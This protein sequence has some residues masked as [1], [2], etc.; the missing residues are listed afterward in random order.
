MPVNWISEL[1]IGD[2][3]VTVETGGKWILKNKSTVIN[4]ER[5]YIETSFFRELNP[6]IEDGL[7]GN[8]RTYDKQFMRNYFAPDGSIGIEPIESLPEKLFDRHI[9]IF[10]QFTK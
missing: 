9:N 8:H 2:E 4:I 7:Q 10:Q 5:M 6:A 1:R 3:V